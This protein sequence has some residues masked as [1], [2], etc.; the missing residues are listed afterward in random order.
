MLSRIPKHNAEANAI[1]SITGQW[2]GEVYL[3]TIRLTFNLNLSQ[4]TLE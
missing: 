4:V 1:V 2:T 3:N